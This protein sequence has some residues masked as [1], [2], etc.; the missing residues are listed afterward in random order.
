MARADRNTIQAKKIVIYRDF[1]SNFAQN[2]HTG[3][4]A[5]V[6]NEDAIKQ[7]YRNLILTGKGERFYD[8]E[9]GAGIRDLLFDLAT[10]E[11]NEVIKLQIMSSLNESEPRGRVVDVQLLEETDT[12]AADF[13]VVYSTINDQDQLY[14]LD[15]HIRRVR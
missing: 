14:S 7:S 6:T 1:L 4:L 8:A 13:R 15:L 5:T 11:H 9:K 3:F 12:N 2:P 10:V